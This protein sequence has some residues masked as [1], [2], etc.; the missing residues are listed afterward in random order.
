MSWQDKLK[1]EEISNEERYVN[2]MDDLK[3]QYK[4]TMFKISTFLR[5]RSYEPSE[6]LALLANSVKGMIINVERLAAERGRK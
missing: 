6:E 5:N 3:Q 4:E 2:A 1:K